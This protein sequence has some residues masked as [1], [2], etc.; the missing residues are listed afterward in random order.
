MYKIVERVNCLRETVRSDWDGCGLGWA[1]KG[2]PKERITVQGELQ[3]TR[4]ILPNGPV[5]P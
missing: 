3:R 2:F 4:W 5:D 1:Q